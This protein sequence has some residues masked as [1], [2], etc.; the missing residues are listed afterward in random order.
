MADIEKI[1]INN[2]SYDIID[3]TAL[4]NNTTQTNGLAILGTT[5]AAANA[6]AIGQDSVASAV[7][8]AVGTTSQSYGVMS[9]SVGGWSNAGNSANVY[10][11]VAIGAG[12]QAMASG[13]I[14][15]GNGVNTDA[16]TFKVAL[17]DSQNM[18]AAT[19]EASGLFTLLNSDGTIPNAR[20]KSDV[21][22]KVSY[23]NPA[24]TAVSG[25][26]TWA[27]THTLGTTD[28]VATVFDTTTGKEVM[29]EGIHTSSTVYTINLTSNTDIASGAYKVVMIG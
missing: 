27:V 9:V 2:V 29:F 20:L 23:T 21:P 24:L 8:T 5:T 6:T 11:A 25:I 12:A 22:H 19:D 26:C 17:T 28:F 14:Q 16:K 15:L 7:T 4:H 13:S 1:S 10:D 18:H 3:A